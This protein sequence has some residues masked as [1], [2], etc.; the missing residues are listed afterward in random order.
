MPISNEKKE[1]VRLSLI[2]YNRPYQHT[3]AAGIVLYNDGEYGE[4]A[5]GKSGNTVTFPL[6][7]VV[8]N[9]RNHPK[10]GGAKNDAEVHVFNQL[11]LEI[12]YYWKQQLGINPTDVYLYIVGP[13]NICKSCKYLRNRFSQSFNVTI[14]T[15]N[16]ITNH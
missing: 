14:E 16:R 2:S 1:E 8:K 6:A 12:I 13:H 4:I 10:V 7:Q 9:H 15:A 3:S 11:G 5:R